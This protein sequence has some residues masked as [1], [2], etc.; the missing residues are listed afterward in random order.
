MIRINIFHGPDKNKSFEVHEDKVYIGRSPVNDIQVKDLSVSRRHLRV[1]RR[2]NSY[3]IMDLKSTNGTFID[4]KEIS[5]WKEVEVQEG[6]PIVMGMTVIGFNETRLENVLPFL[7]SIHW[8][9]D[10]AEKREENTEGRHSTEKKNMELVTKVSHTLMET[11]SVDETLNQVLS[12]IMCLLKRID[13]G[14]I[15]LFDNKTQKITKVVTSFNENLSE[16]SRSYCTK[17]VD[18]VIRDRKA[19]MVSD[20]YTNEEVDLR[21]TLRLMKIGSV[22]CVP[23]ISRSKIMG[24]IYADSVDKPHGFRKEDLSLLSTV[25]APTAIAIENASL[26]S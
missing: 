13:R 26:N 4:G 5:P 23:L 11:F 1:T 6:I 10:P 16:D 24:V 14:A 9:Y 25:S 22:I 19:L 12:S 8:S 18:Q 3:F 20:V 17:V 2:D 15:I 21:D 7:D